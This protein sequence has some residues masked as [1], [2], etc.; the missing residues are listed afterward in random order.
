MITWLASLED[1]DFVAAKM[2]AEFGNKEGIDLDD[3]YGLRSESGLDSVYEREY[4]SGS[5]SE[6]I[7]KYRGTRSKDLVIS[8]FASREIRQSTDSMEPPTQRR[9]RA[10]SVIEVSD[11]FH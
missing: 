11:A 4:K 5:S 9:R 7:P 6:D 8:A 3:T 2:L 10:N 1:D